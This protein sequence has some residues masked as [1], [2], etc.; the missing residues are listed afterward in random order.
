MSSVLSE[1]LINSLLPKELL[2]RCWFIT[3][4]LTF[5]INCG[6]WIIHALFELY[7]ADLRHFSTSISTK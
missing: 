5:V 2:L 4:Y 6:L 7:A 3:F 1:D